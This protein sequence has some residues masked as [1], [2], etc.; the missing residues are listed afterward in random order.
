MTGIGRYVED[1][2][3]KKLLNENDG[4]GTP[5]TQANIIKT[6]F[7]RSYVAKKGKNII[8]TEVGR[9]F[10]EALPRIATT[11]D[12]TAYWEL[13]MKGIVSGEKR[14]EGFLEGVQ[15]KISEL[16]QDGIESGPLTLNHTEHECPSCQSPLRKRS[17]QNGAFWGCRAYPECKTTVP[18]KGGKPDYKVLETHPCPDCG[19]DMKRRKGSNGHF[20]GCTGFP[21][22]KTT[23]QDKRGKPQAQS[24][25]PQTESTEHDCKACGKSLVRRVSIKGRGKEKRETPWYGCSGFPVCKQTYFEVNGQPKY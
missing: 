18:D 25:K 23:L 21:E 1:K 13:A 3:V 17:G 12:M 10:I 19:K 22:C 16:V 7:D 14:L 9:S 15:K 24:A 5:A 11:S 6:L 20:W 2:N 8:S 4:I